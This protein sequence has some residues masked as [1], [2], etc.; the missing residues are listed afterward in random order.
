MTQFLLAVF[1]LLLVACGAP[2]AHGPSFQQA[3]VR[4]A[5][6]APPPAYTPGYAPGTPAEPVYTPQG[7]GAYRGEPLPSTPVERSPNKRIL[8]ASNEPG[9]WAADGASTATL[10][11]PNGLGVT[12][13]GVAFDL[14]LELR[15]ERAAMECSKAVNDASD[16]TIHW[17]K[18]TLTFPTESMRCIAARAFLRCATSVLDDVKNGKRMYGGFTAEDAAKVAEAAKRWDDEYCKGVRLDHTQQDYL[19][20]LNM[21]AESIRPKQ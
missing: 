18:H 11:G 13:L 16:S 7:A 8:P 9:L 14:G 1:L 20:W 10:G 5:P 12:V 2:S 3:A 17:S 4:P 15:P 19:S 21:R 6:A